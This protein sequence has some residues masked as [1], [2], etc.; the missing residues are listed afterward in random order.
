MATRT[1]RRRN[2]ERIVLQLGGRGYEREEPTQE[3]RALMIWLLV[4]L[5][6]LLAVGGGV[7]VSKFLFLLLV[8]AL[9]LAVVGA[10]NRSAT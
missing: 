2:A 8:V 4:L 10:F 1:A 6:L 9:V 5:L 7:A 3:V